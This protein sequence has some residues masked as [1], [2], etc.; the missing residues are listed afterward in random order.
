MAPLADND[1][2]TLDSTGSQAV[3]QRLE[4]KQ[5][6]KGGLRA[7]EILQARSS[8][9]AIVPAKHARQ[10]EKDAVGLDKHEVRR[11]KGL[12]KRKEK[13]SQGLLAVPQKQ[14]MKGS[15]AAYDFAED[16]YDIWSQKPSSSKVRPVFRVAFS[17]RSF[18]FLLGPDRLPHNRSRSLQGFM[19]VV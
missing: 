16:Q 17:Q 3:R 8:Y 9:P 11:L 7:S 6:K 15:S 12:V 19:T 4:G 14:P 13:A 2:F 1:L 5:G 18:F 10:R